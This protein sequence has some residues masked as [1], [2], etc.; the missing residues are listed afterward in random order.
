MSKVPSNIDTHLNK[1]ISH[2][3]PFS[4]GLSNGQNHCAHFVSHVMG[5]ELPGPTCK[6]FTWADNQKNEQSATIRVDDLFKGSPET[7]LLSDKPATLTECLIFVTL[8]SNVKKMGTKLVMGNHPRKHIG[9]LSKGKVWNYGNTYN[10][11]AADVLDIFK[12]KYSNAYKTSG[13][14]VEF[15]YGKFL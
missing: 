1:H 9:I 13:T 8:A 10:K 5:Y 7:G 2:L 3:C 14:T 4:I 11:V 6:N 12:S 15:Y